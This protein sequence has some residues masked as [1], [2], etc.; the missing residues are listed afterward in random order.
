MEYEYDDVNYYKGELGNSDYIGRH[1]IRQVNFE[2][3]EQL[4]HT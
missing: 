3:R 4:L 2:K 1:L